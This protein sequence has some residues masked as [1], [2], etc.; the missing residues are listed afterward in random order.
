[1]PRLFAKAIHSS[2]LSSVMP[3]K[4]NRYEP[5]LIGASTPRVRPT[6]NAEARCGG[7]R[8]LQCVAQLGRRAGH[9]R[10]RRSGAAELGIAR[11][12]QATRRPRQFGHVRLQVQGQRT[13]RE[14]LVGQALQLQRAY[15]RTP[16]PRRPPR[17]RDDFPDHD[18]VAEQWAA[19]PPPCPNR[20]TARATDRR[21]PT[22]TWPAIVGSLL[23]TE[24]T[25][26][27]PPPRNSDRSAGRR[28]R[29]P[30]RRC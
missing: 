8:L 23:R 6:A 24:R 2:T 30:A 10:H 14:R 27:P 15:R 29:P 19:A 5:R 21:R 18:V 20:R 12:P 11:R 13:G 28:T 1:M 3:S 26:R 4:L 22:P 16:T 7:H 17:C 25:D 9:D